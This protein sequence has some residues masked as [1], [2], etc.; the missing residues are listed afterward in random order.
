M[1]PIMLCALTHTYSLTSPTK[2]SDRLAGLQWLV[3][4]LPSLVWAQRSGWDLRKTLKLEPC[5]P[6]SYVTGVCVC[7]ERADTIFASCNWSV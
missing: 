4:V 2:M 3:F 1:T 5:S 6:R 7:R